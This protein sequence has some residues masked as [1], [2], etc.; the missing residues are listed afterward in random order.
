[1]RGVKRPGAQELLV[2]QPP[3]QG[4]V[5]GTAQLVR[6]CE[7]LPD[8]GI[9]RLADELLLL[10]VA[11]RRRD[12]GDK[13]QPGF[14][15]ARSL[16]KFTLGWGDTFL[17]LVSVILSEDSQIYVCVMDLLE[18]CRLGILVCSR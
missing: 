13:D 7:L 5:N 16:I 14:M 3:D 9:F 6:G 2:F 18:V 17:I 4:H 11:I 15:L 10:R 1:E 12:C 8:H